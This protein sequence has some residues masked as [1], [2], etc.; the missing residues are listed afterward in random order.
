M[1]SIRGLAKMA[2]EASPP[3]CR[4][5]RDIE[6]NQLPIVY[7]STYNIGFLGLEKLHPFDSGKWG[8]IFTMLCQDGMIASSRDIV[9]PLEPT[10][11]ELLKVH[12]KSYIDSLRWS[13]N[14]ARVTEVPIV[15]MLP[16]F[17]IQRKV[18]R[19][20]RY[21]TGGTILAAKLALD[22]GWAINIGGGFHHCSRSEGGGFC[23]YADITL[24]I[25][26]LFEHV[27][28]M[29]SAMIV[30]LDAHQGNGHERDFV[31]D[32]RVYILDAYNAGIYPMDFPAR[33]A[34]RRS[35]ELRHETSDDEY[36]RLVE[37]HV[38]SA[39]NEF[40]PDVIVYNAGTDILIGDPLGRLAITAE[41][42]VQRDEIVFKAARSRE[43]PVP[44]V[45]VTSGG[46]Q[47]KTARVIA[48]SILNLWAKKLISGLEL[49]GS[50]SL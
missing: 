31:D 41:G 18:L 17:I 12:E 20:L 45:M 48:D 27:P 10:E 40:R 39:L 33:R 34:I 38:E 24:A 1:V 8:R 16:N 47:K 9:E 3:Q 44:I 2:S 29:G 5:Y 4:L 21:Q 26:Y 6:P 43:K 42:I 11:D 49:D 7:S 15:A 13:V 28:T 35:V 32:K 46:Y 50:S 23:A 22:R 25:H 30:D 14:V 37:R 36:L 19:P